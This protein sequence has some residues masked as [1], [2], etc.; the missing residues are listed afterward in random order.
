[1]IDDNIFVN[2][3]VMVK[4][5]YEKFKVIKARTERYKSSTVINIQKMLNYEEKENNKIYQRI[6]SHVLR[7]T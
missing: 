1:M 5:T 4:R 2:N 3:H 6:V 7:T